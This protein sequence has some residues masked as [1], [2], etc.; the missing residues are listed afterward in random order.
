MHVYSLDRI[1][2][3][4]VQDCAGLY[5]PLDAG[6]SRAMKD[7]HRL[8]AAAEMG[9]V[10]RTMPLT[11]YKDNVSITHNAISMFHFAT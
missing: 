7:F 9:V 6:S 1:N 2:K 3:I 11:L 8:L 4:L 10:K 5:E